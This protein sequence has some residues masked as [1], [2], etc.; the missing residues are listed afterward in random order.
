[1]KSVLSIKRC[2]LGKVKTLGGEGGV[3]IRY[4]QTADERNVRWCRV[5][6]LMYCTTY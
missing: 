5:T 6:P 4:G 2:T 1:M 3:V